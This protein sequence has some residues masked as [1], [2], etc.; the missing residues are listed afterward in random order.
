M[1]N[2]L[3]ARRRIT[4]AHAFFLGALLALIA[5]APAILPYGGRF[6]TRGDYIEQQLPFIL[7]TRRS[8]R[9]GLSGYSFSTFLGAP[10]VG[11]YAFY[12]LGSPFVWP[13]ALLDEALIPYGVSIM[14]VLKH[15][16]CML[17]AFLYL[18]RMTREPR[19][20]LLGSVLYTFSSFT[21]VNTQFYHFTEV[22]AFFPLILLG[23]EIAMSDRPRPGLLALFCGLNTLVNY[24]FMLSSA[25]LAALYFAFRFFSEEWK[26]ARSMRRVVM[27]VFECGIGCALAGVIL[28]PAMWYM[29]SITRTGGGTGSLLTMTYSPSVILERMRALLMPIESNVVHA[30]YGDAHS[31]SSTACHLPVLGMTGAAVLMGGRK[32]GWLRALLAAL[33]VCSVVPV[34]CGAFALFTNVAYTRWWYGLALML[35][36]AAVFAL[37]DRPLPFCAEAWDVPRRGAWVVAFAA[38]TLAAVALTIP[39][40]LPQGALDAISAQGG[41]LS[42]IAQI[43]TN[44]RTG[45]YAGDAFR[46]MAI[47]LSLLGAGVMLALILRRLRYGQALALVCLCACVQYGAYIAVG[48]R[49]ILSGGT[50]P[51]SGVYE[52]SDIA[53]PTLGA[54]TLPEPE[55][56]TRIDYG[57]RLRNYGLLRGQSSLTCFSSLRSSTVGRFVSM[58]GFGYDESTTVRPPD[59]SGA[60]RALLSVTQYHQFDEGET[61]PEGFVYSHEENGFKV[62]TSDAA[63]PMGFLQTTVTGT[64]HQRMDEKTLGQ[65]LLAAATLDDEYLERID[66]PR[67]DVYGIPDWK[68]SA[69]RLRE[70]ACDRFE[71]S[72]DGFSAHIDAKEAGL[73]V[74]TIPYD[75]GFTAAVDGQKAEIIPCDVAFMGVWVEPG[76]HEI[77]F[78]YRTRGLRLGLAMSLIAAIT[79]AGYVLLIRKKAS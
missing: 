40:L 14:A 65:V 17:A 74:F 66:L 37:K 38:C 43:I 78:T 54:L 39:F 13:L 73:L 45:A 34:L 18:R 75:K 42:R 7:E 79:L 16:V 32:H 23:L 28:V 51:G 44:R 19:L 62:Y 68:E 4:A 25:L 27:T 6:V 12:T 33:L 55:A 48:D 46:V 35:A 60:L 9:G 21:I 24:Y 70:N 58:A 11:S 72:P 63:V 64:H 50:D 76:E 36:L 47:T 2:T 69:A 67:L 49:E 59:A 3:T 31:W 52:L 30:F 53:A 56:Y 41:L 26:P 71:T 15:A 22:V 8:M 57:M 10:S 20:A 77:E 5:L 61:I 1:N 29:L